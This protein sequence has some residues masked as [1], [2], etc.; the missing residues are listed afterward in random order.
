MNNAFP[1]PT[2]TDNDAVPEIA[3]G[4]R[5]A[6]FRDPAA[7]VG[8]DVVAPAGDAANVTAAPKDNTPAAAATNATQRRERRRAE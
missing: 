5:V 1:L 3:N 2:S 4:N 7:G 6:L 8:F